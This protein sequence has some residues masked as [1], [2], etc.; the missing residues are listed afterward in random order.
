LAVMVSP[1]V[2][3]TVIGDSLLRGRSGI[4]TARA[5]GR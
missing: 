3:G 1:H 4:V 2:V 5:P